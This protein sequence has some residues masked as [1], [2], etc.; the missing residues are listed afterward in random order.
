MKSFKSGILKSNVRGKICANSASNAKRSGVIFNLI[1][2]DIK[3]VKTCPLLNIPIEY[4]NHV[5]TNN[6]ASLDKI[7]PK[8]GY[9]KGNVEILSLLGNQMK[10]SA[11][12][13]QLITFSKN[14]LQRYKEG[15]LSPFH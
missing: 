9:V 8:L 1:S 6:S 2:E 14:A 12:P 10:S 3:L 13:E 4:G 5:R 15:V 7:N 11:T